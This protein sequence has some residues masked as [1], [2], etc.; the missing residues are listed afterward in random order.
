MTSQDAAY[1]SLQFQQFGTAGSLLIA[2]F[3]CITQL[4]KT[5]KKHDIAVSEGMHNASNKNARKCRL[6]CFCLISNKN[7]VN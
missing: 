6:F 5:F 3:V 2:W 1:V 7:R 4:Q